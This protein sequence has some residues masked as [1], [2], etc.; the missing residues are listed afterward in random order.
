MNI[1]LNEIRKKKKK[2]NEIKFAEVNFREIGFRVDNLPICKNLSL[3]NFSN[4]LIRKVNPREIF[5]KK[6][7]NPTKLNVCIKRSS[8]VIMKFFYNSVLVI[9]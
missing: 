3:R 6:K 1:C 4:S 9:P 8:T 2:K 5:E 7:S